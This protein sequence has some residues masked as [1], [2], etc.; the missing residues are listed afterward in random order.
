MKKVGSQKL[1]EK[2]KEGKKDLFCQVIFVEMGQ[3]DV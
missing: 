3:P 2:K 1:C